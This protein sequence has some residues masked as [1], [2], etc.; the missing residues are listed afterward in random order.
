MAF[1]IIECA[2]MSDSVIFKVFDGY[3]LKR[4]NTT[5]NARNCI[6]IA[7]VTHDICNHDTVIGATTLSYLFV[8]V[9]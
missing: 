1:V 8:R 9:F 2:E 6:C 5:Y 4:S 7:H 3:D